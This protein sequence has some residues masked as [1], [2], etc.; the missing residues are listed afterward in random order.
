MKLILDRRESVWNPGTSSLANS[1]V[2]VVAVSGML[3]FF[4]ISEALNVL[5]FSLETAEEAS[6]RDFHP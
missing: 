5:R 2:R 6:S 3:W 1:T 4:K